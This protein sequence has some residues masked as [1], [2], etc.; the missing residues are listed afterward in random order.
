ME[1]R[2]GVIRQ[3][4]TLSVSI[5]TDLDD[6]DDASVAIRS[7]GS[8]RIIEGTQVDGSSIKFDLSQSDTQGLAPG[9]IEIQAKAR[10]G[11]SVAVSNIM[12]QTVLKS[13]HDKE[14]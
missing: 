3:G 12:T 6:I 13:I 11:G 9:K 5:D 10:V 2:L 1:R 7:G 14:M 4:Q 8:V